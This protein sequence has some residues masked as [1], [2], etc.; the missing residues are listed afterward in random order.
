M[1]NGR[2]SEEV[3]ESPKWRRLALV[4]GVCFYVVIP[5][6]ALVNA[7]RKPEATPV[8]IEV[9]QEVDQTMSNLESS[10]SQSANVNEKSPSTYRY[11][12]SAVN[13]V[14]QYFSSP[15]NINSTTNAIPS[16]RMIF[17]TPIDNITRTSLYPKSPVKP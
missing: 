17:L 12:K 7:V 5:G 14:G 11:F 15:S 16:S 3:G 13:W 9:D 10:V 6:L 2:Y 4:V 1:T 8:R